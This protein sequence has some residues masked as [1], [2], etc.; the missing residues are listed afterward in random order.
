[1]GHSHSVRFKLRWVSTIFRR[2]LEVEPSRCRSL[3]TDISRSTKKTATR[4]VFTSYYG[5]KFFKNGIQIVQRA[6][7]ISATNACYIIPNKI[8]NSLRVLF[9]IIILSPNADK[10]ILHACTVLCLCHEAGI[11]L[12]LENCNSFSEKTD[13]LGHA[14]PPGSLRLDDPTTGSIGTLNHRAT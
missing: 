14:I 7:H 11:T 2:I 1:M 4:P 8:A 5:L 3:D 9:C 10:H 12:I 6:C 13:H